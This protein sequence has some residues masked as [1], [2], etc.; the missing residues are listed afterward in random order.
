MIRLFLLLL[1]IPL[2]I[3]ADVN[4]TSEKE[5]VHWLLEKYDKRIRPVKNWTS[6]IEVTVQPQIYSLVDVVSNFSIGDELREQLTLL[7]WIPQSWQDDYL[8]WNTSEWGGITMVNIPAEELWLPDGT[9]FNILDVKESIPLSRTFARITS[10]GR[11]E[12]D[13]NKLVDVRCPMDVRQFPFDQQICELQFGSWGFQ[14][15]QLIYHVKE[16]FIPKHKGNSEWEIRSFTTRKRTAT[17]ESSM[18]DVQNEYEEVFYTLLVD[19]R[20]PMDVRQFPFDQQI[21]ELQFG[22]W[23]FQTHQLIYH[24]KETFIPKHKGN[25]EWEIRSFTTRKRTATYESS[26]GDVQ[27]EYEEVFY[28]LILRRKPLYYVV[29]ILIPTYLIVS[30]S[31]IGL[32]IAHSADGEREEKILRRKPLYYVVVILIPTYLI[33][34]VSIIGLF[35]AHSADGEREEKVSFGLTTLLTMAVVLDMVTGQMPR[36]SAGLPLLGRYVL[37]ETLVS[38]TA[39]LISVGIMLWNERVLSYNR[40]PPNWI[41]KLVDDEDKKATCNGDPAKRPLLQSSN[42]AAEVIDKPSDLAMMLN[43]LVSHCLEMRESDHDKNIWHRFFSLLD[44]MS[45][46]SLIA[47]NTLLTVFAFHSV[48]FS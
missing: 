41:R 23:G 34:S 19:V 7:L 36:S 18:G 48:I 6:R 43:V 31:I 30:V 46:L 44:I 27:N 28:T 32:F 22:S 38:I 12:V 4:V 42:K 10:D 21:C 39:M 17:Y 47:F 13:L 29:V 37:L 40:R 9:I 1:F 11:V 3:D 26:M 16:T 8:A 20:C 45:M 35:I 25:S 15:H 2:I 33:V 5:L 24:V 14:T